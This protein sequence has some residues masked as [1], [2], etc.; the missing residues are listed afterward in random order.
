[1]VPDI[2]QIK[3]SRDK[4]GALDGSLSVLDKDFRPNLCYWRG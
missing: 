1:M 3:V 4:P 2:F